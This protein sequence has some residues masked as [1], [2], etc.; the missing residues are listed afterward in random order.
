MHEYK[1]GDDE[2]QENRKEIAHKNNLENM[3][4]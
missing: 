3:I 4:K 1:P 2:Q